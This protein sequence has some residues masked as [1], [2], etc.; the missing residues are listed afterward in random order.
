VWFAGGGSAARRNLRVACARFARSLGTD[1][2]IPAG[3]ILEK[4]DGRACIVRVRYE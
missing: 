2:T 4:A 1:F 3:G